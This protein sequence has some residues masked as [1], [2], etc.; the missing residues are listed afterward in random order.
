MTVATGVIYPLAVWGYAQIFFRDKAQG[1]ILLRGGVPAGSRLLGQNFNKP[2]YFRPRPS[3]VG[4][5]PMP[6]GGSNYSPAGKAFQAALKER[7]AAFG[8]E[9]APA[10][11]L[12]A[13]GSGLDPHISPQAARLQCGRVAQARGVPEV[14]II[15]L[16]EG[17]TEPRQLGILG[18]PRVNVLLLNLALDG[19]YAK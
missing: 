7:Q 5:N 1:S 14:D 11:L 12:F 19:K 18:E 13:S 9:A 4:Y 16:V 6:S 10:D 3:A 8:G 15:S 17:M 2:Q